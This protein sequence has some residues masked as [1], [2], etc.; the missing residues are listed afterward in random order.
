MGEQGV[1]LLPAVTEVLETDAFVSIRVISEVTGI[2]G[3]EVIAKLLKE[4]AETGVAVTFRYPP[5][6]EAAVL[7]VG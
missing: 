3:W 2:P 4:A 6:P 1:S 7:E 5:L